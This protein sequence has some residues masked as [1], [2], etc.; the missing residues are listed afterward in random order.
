MANNW[1]ESFPDLINHSFEIYDN[2][3]DAP[4][5]TQ[6]CTIFTKYALLFTATL[7]TTAK[8]QCITLGTAALQSYRRG[9]FTVLHPVRNALKSKALINTRGFCSIYPRNFF[10]L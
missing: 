10:V 9:T 7:P 8:T 2:C 3:T 1:D 5:M 4:D 6:L